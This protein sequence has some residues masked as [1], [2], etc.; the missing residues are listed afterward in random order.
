MIAR[1]VTSDHGRDHF[2]SYHIIHSRAFAIF[3]GDNEHIAQK[4]KLKKK[5]DST[6]VP[7]FIIVSEVVNCSPGIAGRSILSSYFKAINSDE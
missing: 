3:L 7:H 4:K 2:I 6:F 5:I 1:W